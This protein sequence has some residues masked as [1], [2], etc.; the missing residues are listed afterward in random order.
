MFQ[1]VIV[2]W[3]ARR[4]LEL[5]G[6]VGFLY[7]FYL[8]LPPYAQ[9]AIGR[10]LGGDAAPEHYAIALGAIAIAAWGYIWSFRSTVTPQVVT[11]DK[12][13]IPIKPNTQAASKIEAQA[14]VAP[15]PKTLW[16]RLTGR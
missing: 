15:K 6:L 9:A 14:A 12:Q 8:A 11:S 1:N 4:A 16:E 13:Q 5:G 7:S 10:I 2:G 3:A